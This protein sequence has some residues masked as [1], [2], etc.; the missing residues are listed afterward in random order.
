MAI[1]ST[2]NYIWLKKWPAGFDMFMFPV[3]AGLLAGEGLG[4]VFQALLAV[5][6]VGGSGMCT[7]LSFSFFL[8]THQP[9]RQRN[10]RRLSRV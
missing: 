3:A 6:G 7:R 5:A 4:G 8:I 2:F 10:S 1:G 9:Y